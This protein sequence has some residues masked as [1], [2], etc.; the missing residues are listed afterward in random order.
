MGAADGE[1]WD[2]VRVGD[3]DAFVALFRGHS[4]AIYNFCFRRTADWALAED[5]TSAVFLDAST[6]SKPQRSPT[7]SWP[8]TASQRGAW[9]PPG[10]GARGPASPSASTPWP[11]RS[12]SF[13]GNGRVY[14]SE[15]SVTCGRE[16]QPGV[17]AKTPPP[18]EPAY[19]LPVDGSSAKDVT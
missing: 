18:Q 9:T 4:Q 8:S 11:S 15:V 2:R 12:G 13:Q 1:L 19:S 5:L 6:P 7:P 16:A 10:L 14:L 3:P 17:L